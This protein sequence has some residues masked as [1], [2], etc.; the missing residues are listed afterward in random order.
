MSSIF[1]QVLNM[2]ITGSIV[3]LFVLLARIFLKRAPKIY[4]YVLWSVV[5][6]RLL[7]PVSFSA[8]VSVLD[9]AGPRIQQSS[10][11]I[12]TV[13]FLPEDAD[14][15]VDY[16][17]LPVETQPVQQEP[18]TKAGEQLRMTPMHALALLWA[19]GVAGMMVYSVVQ[20]Y[21]LKRKLIGSVC[22]R[23]N[24]Y[25]A[26]HLDTAFVMGLWA[27]KIYLPSDLSEEEI[28]YILA[29]EQHHIR[30]LDPVIRLLSYLA[31]CI[32]WFNPLVWL[33][34]ALAGKD[35]EM[36]CDEAV[37]H[38]LGPEIRA[39]YSA[40]L[41]RL[42]SYKRILSGMPLAFG[43]GDTKGR[44]MNMAK[45]KQPAKW[46]AIVCLILCICVAAFCIF[47]PEEEQDISEFTRRTAE[48][49]VGIG[50]GDLH[51]T[52]PAGLTHELRE[53]ENW[54]GEEELRRWLGM[55]N[56]GQYV[57]IF[58]YKGTVFGGIVDFLVPGDRQIL[59]EEMELPS[60]WEGLDYSSS[61]SIH[62]YAEKEYTLLRDGKEYIRIYLY[63]YSGRGYFLW[64]YAD[65]GIP[66]D[67][68]K[69]EI[70]RS[71]EVGS[72]GR[73]ASNLKQKEEISL[74]F[75][76]AI[77]PKGYGYYRNETVL[78]EIMKEN[79]LGKEKVVATVT[80]RP[81]PGVPMEED[82]TAWVEA[83]GVDLHHEDT[84][85]GYH[86]T[87]ECDFGDVSA[88]VE[89]AESGKRTMAENHYFYIAGNI[90][91][92]LCFDAMEMDEKAQAAILKT[93][94]IKAAEMQ[95]ASDVWV[96]AAAPTSIK[97]DELPQ[98]YNYGFDK[99]Q[100][101][102]FAWGGHVVGGVITYSIPDGLYDPQ[103]KTYHWL[104]E[105]GIPDFEDPDLIYLGGMTDGDNGWSADFSDDA[106]NEANRTVDRHHTFRVVGDTL[107]DIWFDQQ[108]ISWESM[109][110][111]V[112]AISLPEEDP[113]EE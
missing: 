64:F 59:L 84:S 23:G 101:I 4:S 98:G 70:L 10:A 44:V 7:C 25:L 89:T 72:G 31:L 24:I 48:T 43:E 102:V 60:E 20:Y 51:F 75:F 106:R 32:H 108:N 54:T 62:P 113:S 50:V 17:A 39:D 29:H 1:L 19:V 92:D 93:I 41:L 47:N 61:D 45:W 71:V 49:P 86:I 67:Y 80:A 65:Q 2:N 95:L 12:S 112:S 55:P 53:A 97:I 16:V 21:V 11:N 109:Q 82:L 42:T 26:D 18:A 27:P 33:A 83:L 40:S 58:S 28:T 5:L 6:F 30:R 35:M 73:Y 99:D 96:T 100:N 52:Y 36:S 22:L 91:Y 69:Q 87:D 105:M 94:W 79:V 34:F 103:D 107:Y 8:P 15:Q 14:L 88:F 81:L 56:R 37:I 76:N 111:V 63:S 13:S 66:Y 57:H 104:E 68:C 38:S 46:L 85:S 90:V 74:G 3:I 78:L 110:E 77:I 9:A